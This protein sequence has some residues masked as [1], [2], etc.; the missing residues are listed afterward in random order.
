MDEMRE[1]LRRKKL[2]LLDMDGTDAYFDF[3]G[4][5][6]RSLPVICHGRYLLPDG[7]ITES[8]QESDRVLLDKLRCWGYYRAVD[9]RVE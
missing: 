3:L 9:E 6:R 2:F 8:L 1:T 5:L 4:E 7:T